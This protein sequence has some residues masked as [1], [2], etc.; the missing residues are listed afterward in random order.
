MPKPIPLEYGKYYHIYNRGNNR[1][2]VFLEDRNYHY[3]LKLYAEHIEPMADTYAYCLLYNHFHFL[4]RIKWLEEIDTETLRISAEAPSKLS[5][6]SQQF[7]NFFNAYTKGMNHTYQRTGSMFENP[8]GRA[9]VTSEEYFVHLITYIHQNPQKHGLV[10]DFRTWP[11]SSYHALL[12][13]K[14]TRVKRDLVLSWFGGPA[15]VV[16]THQ[17]KLMEH[18]P[19]APEDFD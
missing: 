15:G 9:E 16:A 19:L 4:V 14:P 13:T 12:S 2:N 8:F 11:Y 17:Q 10:R 1:Q 7:G 18:H 5:S 6:P 3:F